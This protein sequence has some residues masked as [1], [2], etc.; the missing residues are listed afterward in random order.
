LG[1]G[2]RVPFSEGRSVEFRWEAFNVFNRAQLGN[3]N[4]NFVVANPD[5]R[6]AGNQAGCVVESNFG[7]ITSPL[8]RNFGTGSNR[9]MQF[10]LRINF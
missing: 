8:N 6:R 9:Q 5:Q 10:M 7:R 2:K 3:P 1:L 4:T